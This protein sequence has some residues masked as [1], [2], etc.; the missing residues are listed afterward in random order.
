MWLFRDNQS[1]GRA[2]EDSLESAG[3]D[4]KISNAGRGDA[5]WCYANK[6][7]RMPSSFCDK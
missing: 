3:D 7:S 5:V 2:S 4:N 6:V 1:P